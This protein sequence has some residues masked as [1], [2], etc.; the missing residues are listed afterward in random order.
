MCFTA[1]CDSLAFSIALS[2]CISDFS[3]KLATHMLTYILHKKKHNG[4]WEGRTR[5]SFGS[6]LHN[7]LAKHSHTHTWIHMFTCIHVLTVCAKQKKQLRL[8]QCCRHWCSHTYILREREGERERYPQVLVRS[9]LLCH[10]Q[11]VRA[12]NNGRQTCVFYTLTVTLTRKNDNITKESESGR[13][14]KCSLH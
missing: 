10:T 2:F 6:F 3:L 5:C 12:H 9:H 1:F 11:L 7:F 8:P 14:S 13:E 4:I